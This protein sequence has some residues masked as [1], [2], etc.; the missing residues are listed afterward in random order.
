MCDESTT[1]SPSSATASINDCRNSRRASGSSEATGSS[2]TS[3]LG[4]LGEGE[5]RAR[6]EPAGRR[7][8]CRPSVRAECRAPGQPPHAPARRPSEGSTY[9]PASS[10]SASLKPRCRGWS[11][12]TNP[13]R[14]STRL[15]L[16]PA[17]DQPSTRASPA[18]GSPSP[19]SQ[20][21]ERRLAGT[22]G[23]DQR[24]HRARRDRQRAVLE[25]PER[26]VALAERLSSSTSRGAA[27]R[28]LPDERGVDGCSQQR[29]NVVLVEPPC[30]SSPL[31]PAQQRR[32]QRGVFGRRGRRS[33]H[34]RRMF[35]V[36]D[37]PR[38][39][40]RDRARGRP[41]APCSG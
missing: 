35:P 33:R 30:L 24:R 4:P 17:S 28:G 37:A 8:A 15:R 2:S 16:L 5:R 34:A 10:I 12:A 26:P 41:S 1:V 13:T 25:C 21:Q 32:L 20:V 39:A 9:G 27:S 6:P 3:S 19:I 40:L 38:R 14:G 18:L 11:W 29:G 23:P 36:R 22:V 31:D 7:R